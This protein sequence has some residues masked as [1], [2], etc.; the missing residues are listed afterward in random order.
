[1]NQRDD[2]VEQLTNH[3]LARLHGGAAAATIAEEF[4]RIAEKHRAEIEREV[5]NR[6]GE[7][8]GRR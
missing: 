4:A 3:I 1:M 5:F 8:L 6:L 7:K 2:R